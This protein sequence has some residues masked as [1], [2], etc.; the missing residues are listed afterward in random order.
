MK[1]D[2]VT[3]PQY[4]WICGIA[5]NTKEELDDAMKYAFH[6]LTM[7]ANSMASTFKRKREAK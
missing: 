1:E 7:I 4:G 5:C 6:P 3:Q 2:K